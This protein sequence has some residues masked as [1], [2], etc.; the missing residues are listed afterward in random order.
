MFY[1]IFKVAIMVFQTHQFSIKLYI[2]HL[3][4]LVVPH[5]LFYVDLLGSVE[6]IDQMIELRFYIFGHFYF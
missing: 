2:F 4:H 3:A 1:L 6:C 5:I